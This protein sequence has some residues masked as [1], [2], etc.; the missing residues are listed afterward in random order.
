MTDK[1]IVIDT[2]E[3]IAYV[4]LAALRARLSL[5]MKGLRFKGRPT[6][7]ILRE[8]GFTGRSR[9]GLLEQVEAELERRL[10]ERRGEVD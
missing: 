2:P 4:R 5:E 3:G 7:V 6:G 1:T 10:E 8:M 9:A